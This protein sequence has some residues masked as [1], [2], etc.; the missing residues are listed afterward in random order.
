VGCSTDIFARFL[1]M[2]LKNIV[3][4]FV[5]WCRLLACDLS[6]KKIL[7]IAFT[8]TLPLVI[9]SCGVPKHGGSQSQSQSLS[10]IT[11]YNPV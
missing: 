4:V 7:F 11:R 5:Y 3:C 10:H 8:V 9:S 1:V 2:W 6:R